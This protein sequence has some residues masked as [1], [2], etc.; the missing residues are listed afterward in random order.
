MYIPYE[1]GLWSGVTMPVIWE[2]DTRLQI[3]TIASFY[4]QI[5]TEA[6]LASV[7]LRL[8]EMPNNVEQDIFYWKELPLMWH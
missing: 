3:A 1:Y 4:S 8:L 6:L 7:F 5:C 2:R